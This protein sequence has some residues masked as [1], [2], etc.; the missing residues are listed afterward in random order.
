MST[1]S[2]SFAVAS[3]IRADII[4]VLKSRNSPEDMATSI[5]PSLAIINQ[6]ATQVPLLLASPTPGCLEV[7]FALRKD[8]F[9]GPNY[10]QPS[11]G[12]ALEQLPEAFQVF[13]NLTREVISLQKNEKPPVKVWSSLLYYIPYLIHIFSLPSDLVL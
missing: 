1:I 8:L 4:F 10:V 6:W 5:S 3:A 7:L 11:I 12:L 13:I 2:P 9:N